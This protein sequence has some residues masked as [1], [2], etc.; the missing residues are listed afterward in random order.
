M[1]GAVGL[2]ALRGFFALVFFFNKLDDFL[3]HRYLFCLL[4]MAWV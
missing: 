3:L 1:D 4:E 2:A